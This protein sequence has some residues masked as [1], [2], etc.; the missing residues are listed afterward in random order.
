MKFTAGFII[1][2]MLV[3]WSS[4]QSDFEAEEFQGQLEFSR[5]TV[6][7]D[8]VFSNLSTSTF[9]L[10]VYNRT[11]E[12]IFIPEISLEGG[13]NSMY[14]LNVDGIPGKS[15]ENIEI[16]ARDSIYIFIETTVAPESSVEKEFLY[17][18]QLQFRSQAHLQKVPLVT[19]VKDAV[20]LYP[21]R[22]EA[23][24]PE[25]IPVGLDDNGEP[26]LVS[27]FYLNEEQL[28]LTDHKPYVIYGYAAVPS[29]KI[30]EIEAG[31]RIYFH[32]DSGIIVSKDA[33]LHITGQPSEDSVQLEKEVIFQG[34]RLE[35]LY[36][37]LA[38]QWG[39]V[40][41]KNG[42]KNHIFEHATFKNAGI[43]ILVEGS[44]TTLTDL[45]LKNVQLYNSAVS[46]ILAENAEITA[47]N[48]VINNSG[49]ASLHLKGGKYSF[50][51][52]TIS[53]YWQQS[54]R[55]FPAVYLENITPTGPAP[56]QAGFFN[57]ILFGN[58][59][60]ELLFNAEAS[61]GFD[62]FFSHTLIKFAIGDDSELYDFN[63][64]GIY[65]NIWINEEPIF[66]DPKNNDL[67]LQKNSAAIDRGDP[68][69]AQEVVKDL[70]GND[71]TPLP[72]LGAYEY[73]EK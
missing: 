45:Q 12:D 30:L 38:G 32:T 13:E 69:I 18:D 1:L 66:A 43:G 56:L 59:K 58:E 20:F 8:T 17:V 54:Y 52:V 73:F 2:I 60:R 25:Q 21:Q 6:F 14:R 11:G 65:H 67:R 4:C 35:G 36:K 57:S 61:A 44:E 50:I 10:K 5:D 22:D 47:E 55:Q 24:F 29:G 23:G 26:Q 41:L 70:L 37:N 31:A 68:E 7:L 39:A 63:N 27:G 34:D 72:D 49:Q 16:L 42:S 64:P 40:W 48:L 15:F 51:H 46:G 33:S 19:L 9:S 71:R 62:V 3:L 28:K 53:N